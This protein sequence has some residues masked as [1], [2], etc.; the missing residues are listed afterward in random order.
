[1]KKR[2]ALNL[3]IVGAFVLTGCGNNQF[4][5]NE[6]LNQITK[7]QNVSQNNPESTNK[8]ELIEAEKGK[9]VNEIEKIEEF[10][11]KVEGNLLITKNE[12]KILFPEGYEIKKDQEKNRRGSFVSYEFAYQ[13]TPYFN[14]IQ[15]FSKESIKQCALKD[16]CFF[17]DFPDLERYNNQRKNLASK[18][19]YGNYKLKTF[20]NRDYFVSTL[21][22]C[23]DGCTREYTT[24]IDDVKIDIWISMEDETQARQADELFKK[25]KIVE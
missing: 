1:M 4:Y 15:F 19:D 14:E 12:T 25:L 5:A 20:N 21:P 16:P 10:V 6:D 3:T 11:K 9:E 13:K 17:D 7:N 23:I 22:S 18:K 2:I 24:F 8:N